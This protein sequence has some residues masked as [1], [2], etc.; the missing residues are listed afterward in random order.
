MYAI[1]VTSHS[2]NHTHAALYL[3]TSVW[4]Y[5]RAVAYWKLYIFCSSE[6]S[7]EERV[8][9]GSRSYITVT[10]KLS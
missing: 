3:K 10:I 2:D 7:R 6:K 4:V 9:L 8:A 1:V 5:D